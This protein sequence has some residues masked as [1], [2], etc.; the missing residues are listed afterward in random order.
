MIDKSQCAAHTR[1]P[2]GQ[3]SHRYDYRLRCLL[4][5]LLVALFAAVIILGVVYMF[6]HEGVL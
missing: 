3:R 6:N 4:M 5:G 2:W 1:T